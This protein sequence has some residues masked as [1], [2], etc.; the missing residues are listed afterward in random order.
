MRGIVGGGFARVALSLVC[1]CVGGGLLRKIRRRELGVGGG[2]G[3]GR[4]AAVDFVAAAVGLNV[5]LRVGG[6]ASR[7]KPVVPLLL[8]EEGELHSGEGKQR[9]RG[10]SRTGQQ[11][12]G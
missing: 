1:G 7:V 2:R 10:W 3:H 6:R 12:N 8:A 4:G 5:A 11:S 9:A